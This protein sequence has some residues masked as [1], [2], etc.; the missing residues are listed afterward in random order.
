MSVFTKKGKEKHWDLQ[1]AICSRPPKAARARLP[2]R[3][4]SHGPT[5]ALLKLANRMDATSNT[6]ETSPETQPL[7]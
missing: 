2:I 3:D 7:I 6:R 5:P 4:V 1:F